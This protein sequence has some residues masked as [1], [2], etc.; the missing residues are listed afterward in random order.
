MKKTYVNILIFI[1]ISFSFSCF[2]Q[3]YLSLKQA[4]LIPKDSV[5]H[6]KISK[7]KL[8][9]VPSIIWR[10][11]NLIALDL[12]KNRLNSIPDSISVLS[13]LEELILRKN[14]LTIFPTSLYN[15]KRTQ[16]FEFKQQSNWICPEWNCELF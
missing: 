1:A 4:L 15:L 5:T 16:I 7:Q 14:K 6:L 10:F 2:S 3:Q 12:S 11:R 8:T 9:E 13:H